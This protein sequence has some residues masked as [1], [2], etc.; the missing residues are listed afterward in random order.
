MKPLK[1]LS[2]IKRTLKCCASVLALLAFLPAQA[3]TQCVGNVAELSAALAGAQAQAA[4]HT[5]LIQQ[6]TYL[7]NQ[8]IDFVLGAPT[9]I[10]GGYNADCSV[11]TISGAVTVINVGPSNLFNL[12]QIVGELEARIS[13]EGLTFSN[14]GIGGMNFEVGNQLTGLAG[15]LDFQR[16]RFTGIASEGSSPLSLYAYGGAIDIENVLIDHLSTYVEFAVILRTPAGGPIRINHLTADLP[17]DGANSPAIYLGGDQQS[18]IQISIYNSI[19]W[20]SNGGH[21]LIE[22]PHLTPD[23]T[24]D[25]V[26]NLY[27]GHVIPVG[28]VNVQGAINTAPGWI[29]PAGGNYQL[30]TSPLSPAINSG[31]SSPPGGEPPFELGGGPRLIDN[32]ADRGAYESTFLGS[33]TF[34]V[35]NKL[36]SGPGSLREAITL[37]NASPSPP[38]V[39]NFNIPGGCP[40]VILLNS[41]LPNITQATTINGQ[42]QPGSTLNSDPFAF[43]ATL[44]VLLKPAS[45][46]L[47]KAFEVPAKSAGRLT[48]RGLGIGGFGQPIRLMGG[49]D[50]VISGNQFGGTVNGISLPG[51]GLNTITIGPGA[52]D[53]LIGGASGQE[54]RNVIGGAS[55]SGI[56]IDPQ[57]SFVGGKGCRIYNNLI[58]LAPN[59]Q[60]K[61]ANTFGINNSGSGCVI[62]F[63]RIA[64]NTGA[65]LWLNGGSDNIVEANN[66]GITT[67]NQGV[68]NSAIG[69][70]VTGSDNFIGAP[71]GGGNTIRFNNAGGV[72]IRGSAATGN[73]VLANTM[74]DNGFDGVSGEHMDVDLQ[75]TSLTIGPNDNDAGD[76]DGGPNQ[77]QNFPTPTNLMFTGP[78]NAVSRPATLSAVLDSLPGVYHIEIYYSG[79]AQNGRGHAQQLLGTRSLTVV[80][81]PTAFTHNVEVPNPLFQGVISLTATDEAGNTSEV[82]TAISIH[83]ALFA[84]GFEE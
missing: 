44:C 57:V 6:G 7:M 66:I 1:Q 36:D 33:L 58:G 26:D 76:L 49:H 23:S 10:K 47:T 32:A 24:I 74:Y 29:N 28:A 5:I 61:L 3:A 77:T 72:V 9:T 83:E 78:G 55:I 35:I 62:K 56:D 38:I 50:N 54:E 40:A 8:D 18:P 70:L 60:T 20:N 75:L 41:T 63:N 16:V 19:V 15:S 12:K 13:V 34:T 48:L 17:A 46:T 25:L 53:T 84:S 30:Q 14:A 52:V 80:G 21:A 22:A 43:N 27:H 69:I 71:G 2:S 37:A 42:T 4:S 73:S 67:Q 79:V 68:S 81:G 11:Q 45:G 59:G 31:S 51:A 64:G 39:I 82:G 65:N